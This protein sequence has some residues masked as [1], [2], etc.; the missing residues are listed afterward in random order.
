MSVLEAAEPKFLADRRARG[1]QAAADLPL[2]RF[3]GTPGWE[4]TPIDDI[5][6][7]AFTAAP[8]GALSTVSEPVFAFDGAVTAGTG[9]IP[10]AV[11]EGPVV[12][13]L[14]V[15]A[16]RHPDLVEKHLGTVAHDS[17]ITARNDALWTD[18][19]F[20]YVPRGVTV[21]A[22]ILISHVH[23]DAGSALYHRTLVV[24]EEGA[25]AEVWEQTLSADAGGE[26]LVNGGVELVVG[27]NAR[28]RYVGAQDLSE[29][30]WVFGAQRATVARDATLDWITLGFGSGNGKVFLE[31]ELTG[32]G[33]HAKVTG[34]YA[35]EGRQHLDFDTLQTHAA[36]NCVS[37]LA[38]RG[39]LAGRSSAVWRGMIKVEE[40]A[41][42]TD[43]FQECRNL[44]IG[45]KA[46]ADAIPGLEILADDVRCTH[47]AAIAQIDP[48][49]LFYLRARG[50]SE[51]SAKRLVI[52]GFLQALVERFEDGPLHDAVAVALERRLERVL[53]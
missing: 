40:G 41:Q 3:R 32:P 48:D 14:A 33:G 13:P 43:G 34:A 30:T 11:S 10:E 49:Q 1:V 18:G 23:E 22:P 31:T 25:E 15:A 27:A 51:T 24:L 19:T 35:T 4:F 47:A 42:Q 8:S 50:L 37:D 20:V 26:G 53:G 7:D 2:P 29:K 16:E 6:L 17:I 46:H 36:P 5:D 9:P 45:K 38:F 52:E 28:L 44:L 39:I 12:L 21:D